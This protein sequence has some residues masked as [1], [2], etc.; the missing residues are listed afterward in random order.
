MS[1]ISTSKNTNSIPTQVNEEDFN[2]FILPYLSMPKR[3]P[4]CQ[5]GYHK[6]FNYILKVLYTGMQWKEL[7]IALN[8]E[9]G[10]RE[11][12]Y[13]NVYKHFAKWQRDGSWECAFNSSVSLLN[14]SDQLDISVIHGD[15]SNTVAKKGGDG[16]GYS[17]HKHQKGEKTMAIVDNNGYILSP[18]TVDSVNRHDTTLLPKSLNHLSQLKK[19]IGLELKG[20]LFNLDAGFDSLINRKYIFNR[21]MK[22]NIKENPR[23]RQQP[24]P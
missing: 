16:I 2:E 8:V 9:T 14:C 20:T 4:K 13:S 22:P 19:S 21:Q 10:Q 24:R 12:H 18:M 6:L 5:I 23:N 1:K 11:I 7:P 3:G 17:G 15:A